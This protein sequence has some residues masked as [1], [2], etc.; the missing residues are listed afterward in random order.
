MYR[1]ALIAVFAVSA[2]PQT[3][4]TTPVDRVYHLTHADTPEEMNEIATA[5]R[6]LGDIRQIFVI[7]KD[8]VMTVHAAS[9]KMAFADWLVGELNRAAPDPSSTAHQYRV[10][11]AD[12][13]V[14]RMFYLAHSRRPQDTL[15]IVTAVRLVVDVKRIFVS[16]RL[17]AMA[18]S[19][20][21]AQMHMVEWLVGE[22]DKPGET[23]EPGPH[24]YRMTGD[25][26]QVA[27]VFYLAH[28]DT[29]QDLQQIAVAVRTSTN[30]QWL[31]INNARKALTAR[32][33]PEQIAAAERLIAQI[34]HA[35]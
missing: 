22:L 14:V 16:N 34:G 32:G 2:Y 21:E 29:P 23:I 1:I 15:E 35:R 9:D 10:P 6:S 19:G 5:V 11:G 24:E 18:V 28:V 12:D 25:S 26:D 30:M 31:F 17:K 33:T 3:P 27:R 4:A 7:A 20:T 13:E 8:K